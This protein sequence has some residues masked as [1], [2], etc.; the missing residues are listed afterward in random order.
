MNYNKKGF[1]LQY[2][3]GHLVAKD[4]STGPYSTLGYPFEAPSV[5]YVE[6]F[7]TKVDAEKYRGR[8]NF[9]VV[10]ITIEVKIEPL[11]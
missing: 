3:N 9:K 7:P 11:P 8:E 10:G 4:K 2:P 1:A 5:E 6:V